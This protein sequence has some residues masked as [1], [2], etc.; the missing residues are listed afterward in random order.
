MSRETLRARLGKRKTV[1]VESPFWG[2]SVTL[3]EL[4]AAEQLSLSPRADALAKKLDVPR[5]MTFVFLT[6]VSSL[7]DG[8][9]RIFSDD[10][11]ADVS[12]GDL[13]ELARLSEHVVALNG[14]RDDPLGNSSGS[15]DDA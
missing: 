8:D 6:V 13:A 11:L 1:E 15:P 10:D 14:S 4:S 9:E 12:A 3:R 2:C 5:D 7:V